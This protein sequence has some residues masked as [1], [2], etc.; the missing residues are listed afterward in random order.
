[1]APRASA[2]PGVALLQSAKEP[3]KGIVFCPCIPEETKASV[4]KDKASVVQM[5]VPPCKVSAFC[6]EV[7][8]IRGGS[9]P[10]ASEDGHLAV[11]IPHGS[12]QS[13]EV[14]ECA[15]RVVVQ[16]HFDVCRIAVLR[17]YVAT[18]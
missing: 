5:L 2:V 18:A 9:C 4:V 1:V 8:L 3:G 6:P 11:G 16:Q 12:L 7:M 17:L 15:I 10:S 13:V 14:A